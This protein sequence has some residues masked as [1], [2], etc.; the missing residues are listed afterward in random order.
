MQSYLSF[1]D[2]LVY[3]TAGQTCIMLTANPETCIALANLLGS[4]FFFSSLVGL[5][6]SLCSNW[7]ESG[8]G[9]KMEAFVLQCGFD[10]ALHRQSCAAM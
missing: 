9:L 3:Y 7:R 2:K 5:F 4:F 8:S 6:R 10:L 1:F